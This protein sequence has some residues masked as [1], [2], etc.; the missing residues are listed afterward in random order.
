MLLIFSRSRAKAVAKPPLSGP[1]DEDIEDGLAV[2]MAL[3]DPGMRRVVEASEIAVHAG[4]EV[5]ERHGRTFAMREAPAV[6]Q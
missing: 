4:F 5:R 3:R 6:M 2:M 1:D